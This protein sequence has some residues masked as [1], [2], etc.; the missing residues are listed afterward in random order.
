MPYKTI[1]VHV[2]ETMRVSERLKAAADLTITENA[3]LVGLSMS[4]LSR[5][6][7]QNARIPDADP[8]LSA[9]LDFL[10]ECARNALVAFE[11]IARE[12]A[13]PSFETRMTD[14]DAE[15]GLCLHAR[16]A[17][18]VVMGQTS[19]GKGSPTLK[20][21]FP[22]N[23]ILNAGRPVLVIPYV[24]QFDTIGKRV[25]I[26]WDASKEATRAVTNA[27]PFLIRADIVQ[28]AV[29]NPNPYSNVHGEQPGSDIALFLARHGV[30][31]ELSI[32]H[33]ER[34]AAKNT[35]L[36][37]GN[38]LLSLASDLSSDLLVMGAYG[39][40]RFRETMLGGVTRTIMQTMTLPVLMSH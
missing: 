13:V 18:L 39:H 26:A 10:R 29:F 24:G 15:I 34:D 6:I 7:Y 40:S 5:F 22:E 20:A 37:V 2:D 23:V 17:D 31:V 38:A 28:I 9:H 8:N 16:Y 25:L 3:H 12:K 36:D 1:L 21:D 30:K 35:R 11:T 14:D 19:E 27:L 32:H 33:T 4:G